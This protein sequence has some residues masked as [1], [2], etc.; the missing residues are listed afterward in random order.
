MGLG[1]K[2]LSICMTHP[3]TLVLNGRGRVHTSYRYFMLH[4]DEDN[5]ATLILVVSVSVITQQQREGFS[6][7]ETK[8]HTLQ[9]MATQ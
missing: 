8:Q 5:T 7:F 4:T 3:A 2:S 6:M 9:P 1:L